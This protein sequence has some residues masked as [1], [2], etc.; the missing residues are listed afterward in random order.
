MVR[1]IVEQDGVHKYDLTC[2]AVI[3]FM[4]GLNGEEGANSGA[5]F[6]GKGAPQKIIESA[7]ASLGEMVREALPEGADR[8]AA[9]KRVLLEVT[10]GFIGIGLERIKEEKNIRRCDDEG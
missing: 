8:N 7:A 5:L 1:V 2:E 9:I 3:G 6:I 4:A 10:R